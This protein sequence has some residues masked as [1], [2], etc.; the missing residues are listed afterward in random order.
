M[1]ADAGVS[2]PL[3]LHHFGSREGLL[4]ALV[5]RALLALQQDVLAAI[6][7]RPGEEVDV[8]AI[9]DRVFHTLADEGHA[10]L[11]AGLLLSGRALGGPGLEGQLLRSV[12]EASHARRRAYFEAARQAPPAFEDSLF[13]ILLVA[14]ALF[15]DALLGAQMRASAGLAEDP[16]AGRRFRVWLARLLEE[17]M[18]RA[19]P[20]RGARR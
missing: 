7:A 10:R 12:A 18:T 11:L 13:T 6:T 9:L 17:H 16:E 20:P 4:R 1:A 19:G 5:R 8:R 14:I 15:G 2:H 3:I